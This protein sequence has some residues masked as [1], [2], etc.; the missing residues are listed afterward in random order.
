MLEVGD[1]KRCVKF[2]NINK[3][4][5]VSLVVSQSVSNTAAMDVLR[6]HLEESTPAKNGVS[7]VLDFIAGKSQ[8]KMPWEKSFLS[9]L[10]YEKCHT[11]PLATIITQF[12]Q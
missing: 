7:E 11:E 6:H 1:L 2:L 3:K 4:T 10:M 8:A 12:E 5:R 9:A